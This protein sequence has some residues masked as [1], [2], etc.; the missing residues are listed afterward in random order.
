MPILKGGDPC[1]LNNYH[2]ISKLPVLAKVFE[3]IVNDQMKQYLV[4]HN[5]LNAFQSGFSTT[6]ATT[7]LITNDLITA[8]VCLL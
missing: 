7:T 2:P 3:S 5:I 6:T 4:S 8:L 1:D